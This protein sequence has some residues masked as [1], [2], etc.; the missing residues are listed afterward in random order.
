[1]GVFPL[2]S[3]TTGKGKADIFPLPTSIVFLKGLWDGVDEDVVSWVAC[4]CLSLNSLWG[5][6]ITPSCGANKIQRECLGILRT[7]VER[8][9]R[10]N[11]E[12][13][14]GTWQDFFRTRS[15][16]YQ[17]DE[18]RVA[19]WIK[20]E[21]VEPALPA[22]IGRVPL[23]E[24]CSLGCREYVMSFDS[25][26]KPRDSW[27][28]ITSPK[29]MVEDGAWG[30]LCTGLVKAGVCCYLE[31]SMVFQTGSGPLLNG[32]FGVSKEEWTPDGA[33]IC[34][35]IMNLTP[36]NAIC[37]PLG[38]DVDTSLLGYDEPLLHS[39]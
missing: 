6:S 22:E 17:G 26:L 21:N 3:S 11:L 31:E 9:C 5:G 37:H 1:M 15:I 25:Y 39:A 19:R 20:W 34:R 28:R 29:V 36:L 4:V 2:R 14:T 12:L 27:D 33:E 23:E 10:F 30:S 35:L 16:D 8:F 24:V 7:E 32:M 18:V 13:N 38:G